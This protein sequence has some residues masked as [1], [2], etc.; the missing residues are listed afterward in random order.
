MVNKGYVQLI[1]S[2]F[3]QV[4]NKIVRKDFELQQIVDNCDNYYDLLNFLQEY[5]LKQSIPYLA[6][7]LSGYFNN[8]VDKNGLNNLKLSEQDKDDAN[9]IASCFGRNDSYSGNGLSI[10]YTTLLGTVEF[11]Y[12]M[13]TFP[14]GIF[15]DVFGCDI[16]HTLP[17]MPLVGESEIDFYQRVIEY[18]I[19]IYKN[20]PIDKRE[21]VI[22][23]ARRLAEKFCQSDNRIYL[24]PF[25]NV[26][27]NKASFGDINGLRNG[28]ISGEKLNEILS[29]LKTF[30]EMVKE[31]SL[32][33]DPNLVDEF[34]VAIYGNINNKGIKYFEVER[35]YEL[36]QRRARQLNLEE[37]TEIPRNLDIYISPTA[38][39][40]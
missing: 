33:N 37:G 13:Q 28:K 19:S 14:A 20:F 18:R 5:N 2:K 27:N 17:I 15:E 32:Y 4:Y 23:R 26:I 35:T 24:I 31:S 36:M 39:H 40:L 34:G 29:Y 8:Q 25:D 22:Y 7:G 30:G 3:L 6:C 12:G 21:E 10:I 16:D 9:F 1:M 11:S 38:K